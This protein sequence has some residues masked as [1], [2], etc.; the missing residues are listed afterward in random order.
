MIDRAIVATDLSE[1]SDVMIANL[2]TVKAFGVKKL[3]LLQCP[4]FQEV[5]SQM[6]PYE[7]TYQSDIMEKEKKALEEQGFEV[8]T[9]ISP[10]NAKREIN[11]IAQEEDIPLVIVGS[12]GHSLIGGAFLGG[13]ASEVI[14]NSRKPVLIMRLE[15]SPEKGLVFT[16]AGE[17]GLVSN[18]LYATDFSPA[19]EKAFGTLL[20]IVGQG[21]VG[22]ITLLHVQDQNRFDPH[23]LER[24]E[25]FNA[26]DKNRLMK[27]Q[28]A[29]EEKGVKKVTREVVYGEPY[30]EIMRMLEKCGATLAIL[31]SQGRGFLRE[32]FVG[33]VS[34]YIA[35]RSHCSVL[36]VPS[37]EKPE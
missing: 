9:K 10:G 35:R 23:L 29:L 21:G 34:Q 4:S 13:V 36:L 7:V 32:L 19:S 17:P 37:S 3:L 15:V 28:V 2:G 16:G 31:G 18:I 22:E 25:E 8:E 24:L 11:R 6:Y 5:T 26:I 1:A 27:L 33:S 20:D 12:R 30:V 14:L